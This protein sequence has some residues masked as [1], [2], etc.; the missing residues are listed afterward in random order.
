MFDFRCRYKGEEQARRTAALY[1]R[2]HEPLDA[3]KKVMS[4][5][6]RS[7]NEA[8]ND[9]ARE[10]NREKVRIPILCPPPCLLFLSVLPVHMVQ[11]FPAEVIWCKEIAAEVGAWLLVAYSRKCMD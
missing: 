8:T 10:K 9:S 3:I 6:L 1:R 7:Y 2:L 11:R 4:A 5:L